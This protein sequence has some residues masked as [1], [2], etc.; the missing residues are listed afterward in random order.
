VRINCAAI[1][2]ELIESEIFGYERGAFTG[3]KA[4]GK[5][6]KFEIA[7]RGTL[8]LDEI[9][10]MPLEMQPK[11]LRVLEEKEFERLGGTRVIRSD[12]RVIAATNKDLGDLVAQEK[13]RTD[14]YYRLN[15]IHLHIPPLRERRLPHRARAA[16]I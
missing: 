6:G 13:F 7:N 8:F 15:V 14:L 2:K 4:E 12:F 16:T 10:D 11:L 1:P 5:P 3:A 9:G